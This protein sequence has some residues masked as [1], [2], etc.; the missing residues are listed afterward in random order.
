MKLSVKIVPGASRTEVAGWLDETLKIRVSA[1]P[2]KGKANQAVIALLADALG[3]AVSRIHITGGAT[4]QRKTLEI[5]D[6]TLQ[7]LRKKLQ[8]T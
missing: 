1:P 2:E 6:I 8:T 4:N 7:Q 5:D 3:I